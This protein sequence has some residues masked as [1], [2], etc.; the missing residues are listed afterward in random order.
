MSYI[1]ALQTIFLCLFTPVKSKFNID[2]FI[3]KDNYEV[4]FKDFFNTYLKNKIIE[5]EKLRLFNLNIIRTIL[6]LF[7]IIAL[8][9]LKINIASKNFQNFLALLFFILFF[10]SNQ[11]TTSFQKIYTTFVVNN[12]FK[13]FGHD[14]EYKEN[15]SNFSN[16]YKDFMSLPQFDHKLSKSFAIVNAKHQNVT[17]RFQEILLKNLKTYEAFNIN[18]SAPKKYK[19]KI[20]N[21]TQGLALHLKFD[22]QFLSHIILFKKILGD[23]SLSNPDKNQFE[24][25][26]SPIADFNKK[27]Y[28]FTSNQNEAEK[29]LSSNFCEKF[30]QI[31]CAFNYKKMLSAINEQ[32]LL[33]YFE[34]KQKIFNPSA[35]HKPVNL[36]D[37]SQKIIQEFAA[38]FNFIDDILVKNS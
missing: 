36:V 7:I 18:R 25:F 33:I 22:T 28:I 6:I 30:S 5:I 1:H 34:T 35:L 15:S 11:L 17:I 19:Q 31:D 2:D 3:A 23:K 16:D 4:G 20:V 38:I 32:Q 8:V 24:K 21:V 29:I 37:Q 26:E 9:T 12:I 27:F 13:Y 14:F 10:I